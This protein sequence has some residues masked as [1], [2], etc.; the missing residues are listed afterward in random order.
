MAVLLA[1]ALQWLEYAGWFASIEGHVLDAVLRPTGGGEKNEGKVVTVEID[2]YFYKTCFGSTSPLDPKV[3]EELVEGTA[4]A[5]PKVIG[6]DIFTDAGEYKS[7]K[8]PDLPT[9]WVASAEAP[10]GM[11]APAGDR[12]GFSSWLLGFPAPLE[13]TPVSVLGFKFNEGAPNVAWGLPL[14]PRAEDL[15]LRTLPRRFGGHGAL[16]F[17]TRVAKTYCSA[18]KARCPGNDDDEEIFVSY[19]GAHPLRFSARDLFRCLPDA[20]GART[21]ARSLLFQKFSEKAEG[22]IVL[23]GGTFA[24][25]RDI[26]PTPA[27]WIPGLL[28]NAYAVESELAGDHVK[29]GLRSLT[30]GADIVIGWLIVFIFW[31]GSIE[32]PAIKKTLHKLRLAHIVERHKIR[33]MIGA[34]MSLVPAAFLV[35]LA[36]LSMG[37]YLWLTWIG[38]AI[39]MGPHV[40]LEIWKM[41]PAVSEKG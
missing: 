23:L 37:H 35:S 33:W 16:A 41:N 39:G 8:L 18:V 9:V 31:P 5:A 10:A 40:I 6:V 26:Y 30:F 11:D 19:K 29:E 14:Y 36:V 34:S 28:L 2:D 25:G 13:A 15:S 27:G 38:V 4:Q 22:R 20:N 17:A 21:I 32:I 24:A 3:I 12:P 1:L 7:W